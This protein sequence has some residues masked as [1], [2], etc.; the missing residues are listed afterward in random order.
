MSDQNGF[1]WRGQFY[2]WSVSDIGKDLMLIDRI[3]QIPVGAF[4]ELVV[5]AEESER[6]PVLLALVATSIR[7][8][9]PEWSVDRIYRAVMG[10]SMSE[11]ITFVYAEEEEDEDGARPLAATSPPTSEAGPSPSI[12]SSPPSIHQESTTSETSYATPV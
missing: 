10:L 3:A 4:M 1:E 2:A 6:A 12:A 5:D 8:V 7:R 11:D 9:H